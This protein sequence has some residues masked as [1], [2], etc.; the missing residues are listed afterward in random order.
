MCQIDCCWVEEYLA[1]AGNA[2]PPDF[3]KANRDDAT[4][5]E[6]EDLPDA[7]KDDPALKGICRRCFGAA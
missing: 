2:K 7:W 3:K 4:P 6:N 1:Y 5:W